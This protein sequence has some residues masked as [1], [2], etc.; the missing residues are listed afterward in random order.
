MSRLPEKLYSLKAAAELVGIP[1][2]TMYMRVRNG[3]QKCVEIGGKRFIAESEIAE[4]H[5]PKKDVV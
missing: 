5:L 3:K 1:Y 2:M 4:K